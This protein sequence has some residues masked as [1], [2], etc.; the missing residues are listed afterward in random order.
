MSKLLRLMFELWA[1]LILSATSLFI[2]SPVARENEVGIICVLITLL[3]WTLWIP[4]ADYI[5]SVEEVCL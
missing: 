1:R 5:D 4:I 3:V 2:F